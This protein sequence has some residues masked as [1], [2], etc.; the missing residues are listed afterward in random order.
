MEKKLPDFEHI[1][2]PPE[3]P[4]RPFVEG[5]RI[6]W[7]NI[8]NGKITRF[9]GHVKRIMGD[10]MICI[11]KCPVNNHCFADYLSIH[12]KSITRETQ[13]QP[14]NGVEYR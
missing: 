5:D 14:M 7:S 6:S 8:F 12:D 10:T 4:S 2:E 1:P 13:L 3:K 9:E 11:G